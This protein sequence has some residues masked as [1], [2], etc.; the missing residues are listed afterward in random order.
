[1]KRIV[2]CPKCQA[3]LSVFDSGKPIK[4]KCPKC[5]E[6]FVVESEEAKSVA[7]K[8]ETAAETTVPPSVSSD[9][10]PATATIGVTPE[11]KAEP[12]APPSTKPAAKAALPT[13]VAATLP[14]P[15]THEHHGGVSFQHIIVIIVL[16]LCVIA[17]QFKSMYY[18][19]GRF[20][21]L[22]S[23]LSEMHKA[24]LKNK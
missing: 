7:T 2:Q 19:A 16:L 6:N 23:Q 10:P 17:M 18:A 21:I 5:S 11:K 4:Q 9:T 1:M 24:L 14:S 8:K 13:P 12:K 15:E 3:K 22:E 20:N